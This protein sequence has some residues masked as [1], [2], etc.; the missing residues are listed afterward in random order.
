M[1]KIKKYMNLVFEW[2]SCYIFLSF[3]VVLGIGLVISILLFVYL[4]NG[5]GDNGEYFCVLNLNSFYCVNGDSYDNVVYFVKDFLIMCYFN[6]IMM[7][8][9]FI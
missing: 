2:L 7:Y 4:I 5:L 9:V 3:L 6:E 8:F 1:E